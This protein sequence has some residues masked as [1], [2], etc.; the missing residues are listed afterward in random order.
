MPPPSKGTTC[1]R[2][3]KSLGGPPP[4]GESDMGGISMDIPKD[5]GPSPP[6]P[7][8]GEPPLRRFIVAANN[9]PNRSIKP[10][11]GG[12]IAPIAPIGPP[13]FIAVIGFPKTRTELLIPGIIPGNPDKAPGG[14][15][16][17]T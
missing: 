2:P 14:A 16:L 7:F 15:P 8:G 6:S 13:I 5:N 4:N 3:D 1:N 17:I 12:P 9:A 10:G 11:G